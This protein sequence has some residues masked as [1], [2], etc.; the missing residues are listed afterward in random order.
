[1]A[2]Y[3]D[4]LKFKLYKPKACTISSTLVHVWTF[5]YSQTSKFKYLQGP[6]REGGIGPIR[7]SDELESLYLVQRGKLLI[8]FSQPR[9]C[10]NIGLAC[11]KFSIFSKEA[12]GQHLIWNS[13]MF[14][15]CQLIKNCFNYVHE[16]KKYLLVLFYPCLVLFFT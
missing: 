7:D 11:L 13:P 9:P 10:R 2:I 1:M 16:I 6:G 4:K 12:R 15:Y 14:K 3:M 8:S 5:L